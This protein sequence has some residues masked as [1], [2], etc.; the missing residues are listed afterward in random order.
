MKR[1]FLYVFS[2][3]IAVL[4]VGSA[5]AIDK[6]LIRLVSGDVV[7]IDTTIKTLTVKGRKAE[8]VIVADDKTVVKMDREKKTLSDVKIGDKVT[9][10]YAVIEGNNIARTIDIKPV[11]AEKKGTEPAKPP[12][13]ASKSGY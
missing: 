11:K 10:K 3:L 13:P 4:M 7:T 9:V 1:S 12:K 2:F 8:V 5:I 6:V